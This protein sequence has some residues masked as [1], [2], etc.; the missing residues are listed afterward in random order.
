VEYMFVIWEGGDEAEAWPR[1][2]M[3]AE[4]G[5]YVGRLAAG[6]KLRGGSA[7][8]PPEH[9]VTVRRRNGRPTTVDGPYAETK[10]IMGGYL[11]VEAASIDEA[12]RLLDDCPALRFGGV[13][14]RP[15]VPQA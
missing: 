14:V 15:V 1:E 6:G 2:Q 3:L 10:E 5:E 12:V 8:E 4:M 13:E 9:G 11:I 7:L